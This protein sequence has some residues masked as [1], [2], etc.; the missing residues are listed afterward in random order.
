MAVPP[1]RAKFNSTSTLFYIIRYVTLAI[2][3]FELVFYTN[4]TGLIKPSHT[5]CVA[6]LW[7]EN[8][9][10]FLT[11]S[12]VD[13]VLVMRVFAFYGRCKLS[14]VFLIVLWMGEHVAVATIMAISVPEIQVVP[15]HLP[16]D[17]HFSACTISSIPDLFTTY[18][19]PGLIFQSILL[20]LVLAKFIRTRHSGVGRQP[21]LTVLIRDG[22]WAYILIVAFVLSNALVFKFSP[23]NGDITGT[24]FYSVVGFCG[25][26]L[27]LNLRKAA[28]E[29][30]P[31]T[32]ETSLE[33]E[34]AQRGISETSGRTTTE[35]FRP[36]VE[37]DASI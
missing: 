25:S 13:I 32:S 2:K 1:N 6:W 5:T 9:A 23:G 35:R 8:I 21:L 11:L 34:F 20:L 16:P 27:I 30:R 31:T 28:Y 14:L 4:I 12:C 26:R 18:W 24:W 37:G 33:F 15:N 36:V 17:V 7:F 3:I 10:G 22:V 29:G 19:I